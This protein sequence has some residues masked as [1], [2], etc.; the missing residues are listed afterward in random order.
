MVKAGRTIYG[1][2]QSPSYHQPLPSST[3]DFRSL[4]LKMCLYDVQVEARPVLL[5]LLWRWGMS[6]TV[7]GTRWLA[8]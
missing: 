8:S 7:P 6:L 3:M 2:V 1:I 4:P 5:H